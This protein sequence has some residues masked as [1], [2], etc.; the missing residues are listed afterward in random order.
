MENP[1]Y[2]SPKPNYSVSSGGA[3]IV[4]EADF[5]FL[6]SHAN[7]GV[8][9]INNYEHLYQ[10]AIPNVYLK[11]SNYSAMVHAS[12]IRYPLHGTEHYNALSFISP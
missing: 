3:E 8:T 10:N 6:T 12:L 9:G 11:G 5:K 2:K 4:L 7:G 1:V